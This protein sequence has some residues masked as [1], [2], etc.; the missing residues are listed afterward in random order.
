[1]PG[2]VGDSPIIGAGT[3]CDNATCGVSCTG[4]G[5]LFIRHALAHQVVSLMR[6]KGLSV[7]DAAAEALR[8]LPE[9]SGGL[10][11][12]DRRGNVAMPFNTEGMYRGH[13]TRA[14]KMHVAIYPE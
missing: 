11:A 14:G 10:I 13:I 7:R 3:Y 5:E 1:M 6:Y 8:Q 4:Y 2:R 12:L 9:D